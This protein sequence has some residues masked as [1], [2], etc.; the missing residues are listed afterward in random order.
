MTPSD[1]PI[2]DRVLSQLIL[3][4]VKRNA[5]KT[6]LSSDAGQWTYQEFFKESQ[7]LA[8]GLRSMGVKSQ[9]RV[10]L[11]MNNRAEFMIAYWAIAFLNA[12]MIPVNTAL[13]GDALGYMFKDA[14]ANISLVDADLLPAVQALK[15][16][17]TRFLKGIVVLDHAGNLPEVAG[18]VR[19]AG[20]QDLVEAHRNAP[21]LCEKARFDDLHMISYTS[22][23]TGPA[24]GVMI[25][26]AQSIQTSL[27]CIHAVGIKEDDVIYAP[28]PLFHGMSRTM[29]TIP[30]LLVGAQAH[31]APRFSGASFW[32]DITR[33][34][35]TVAV[36]IF[37]IPPTLKS[38]PPSRFD[39]A[40]SLRVMFNA[41]HDPEFEERFGTRIVE[42]HGMT[43]VGITVYSPY[44][45]RREGAAGRAAEDWDVQIVD[46]YDRILPPG[47]TGEMVL[48]PRKPSIMLKG[49]L[50]KADEMVPST[51]NL[52]FHT[53][54]F[55][56][57]DEDGFLY[58][59]GRKKER[60]RRRGENISAYDI[61]TCASSH[62]DVVECAAVAYPAGDGEDEVRL[63][64][65]ILEGATLTQ[66]QLALWLDGQ[67]A[68]FMRPRFIE[69]LPELPKT[70][71]GKTEKYRIMDA[72]LSSTCWDREQSLTTSRN[73]LNA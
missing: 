58:F 64:V 42:A 23:T 48:R 69:F 27:T 68:K 25:S 20:Y 46:E 31:I 40:H 45:E 32:D 54:D 33:L 21:L 65:V 4:Q 49:Y 60:I 16:E 41:H 59:A 47:N 51:R 11:L 2:E 29:G 71:S 34:K 30:A 36:T 17:Y 61:E 14:E 6:Y 66:A 55:M 38:R 28:L 72:P 70:G 9:T 1:I 39:H 52:W 62:P 53:G 3:A 37:T 35:A 56:R 43:E 18:G 44:P 26:Y 50:N 13:V 10:L 73:A 57:M 7:A 24:K 67:L 8:H 19:Y 5:S 15:P 12:T 22:G 63:A